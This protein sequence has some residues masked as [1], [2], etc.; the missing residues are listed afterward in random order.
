MDIKNL[1][2]KIYIVFLLYIAK[3]MEKSLLQVRIYKIILLKIKLKDI[4]L[5]NSARMEDF[6]L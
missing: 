6:F 3:L 2:E 4:S 5:N 1:Q